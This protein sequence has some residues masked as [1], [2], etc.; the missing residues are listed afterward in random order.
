M[1]TAKA[2]ALS[3]AQ[4]ETADASFTK[5]ELERDDGVAYYE[6]DFTD[7][8]G[9]RYEYAVDALTGTVIAGTGRHRNTGRGSRVIPLH[10]EAQPPQTA[11]SVRTR[12]SALRSR[13]RAWRKRI[14]LTCG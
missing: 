11:R 6:V 12:P 7:A 3:A 14:P 9:Q 4:V 13:T 1:E 8:A 5:V 10:R 2:A